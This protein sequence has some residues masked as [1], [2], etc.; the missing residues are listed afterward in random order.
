VLQSRVTR[1]GPI[2]IKACDL[3]DSFVREKKEVDRSD[4]EHG[5]HDEADVRAEGRFFLAGDST[6]VHGIAKLNQKPTNFVTSFSQTSFD[7]GRALQD[8]GISDANCNVL[9]PA[10]EEES[11]CELAEGESVV[12]IGDPVAIETPSHREFICIASDARFD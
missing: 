12:G 9:S 11:A 7:K 10:G 6:S 2:R 1:H 5:Y 4:G 8:P 3:L